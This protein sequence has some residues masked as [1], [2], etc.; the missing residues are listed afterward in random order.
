MD[1]NEHN[2]Q[3]LIYTFHLI[4]KKRLLSSHFSGVVGSV[5]EIQTARLVHGI[6]WSDLSQCVGVCTD[7]AAAMTSKQE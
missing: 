6:K 1:R 3:L 4:E 7:E 2:A 5:E